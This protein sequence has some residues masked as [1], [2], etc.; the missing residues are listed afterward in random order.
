MAWELRGAVDGARSSRG[1]DAGGPAPQ[2]VRAV[3]AFAPEAHSGLALEGGADA[4]ALERDPRL[5]EPPA[6]VHAV[7]EGDAHNATAGY[8]VGEAAP[9][10]ASRKATGRDDALHGPGAPEELAASP[11]LQEEAVEGR[12]GREPDAPGAP[13]AIDE[14]TRGLRRSKVLCALDYG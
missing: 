6:T 8:P 11:A 5:H 4:V 10:R 7:E 1:G 9:V 12:L 3:V 13:N 14:A 2:A